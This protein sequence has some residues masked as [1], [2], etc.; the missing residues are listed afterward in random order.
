MDDGYDRIKLTV[1]YENR[2]ELLV[3]NIPTKI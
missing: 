3:D 2:I 1:C